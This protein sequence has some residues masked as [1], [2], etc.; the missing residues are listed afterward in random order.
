MSSS[1]TTYKL[2]RKNYFF[3]SFGFLLIISTV[4]ILLVEV[5]FK[6]ER[7]NYYSKYN[8]TQ[9]IVLSNYQNP[10]L[11]CQPRQCQ[12]CTRASLDTPS[13]T[14]LFLS[15]E[16]YGETMCCQNTEDC[17][18]CYDSNN[19]PYDCACSNRCI[20]E[21]D[22]PLCNNYCS[23]CFHPNFTVSY[24]VYQINEIIIKTIS[25][26]CSIDNIEC[27][28][29]FL[30]NRKQGMILNGYY[31][32]ENYYDIVIGN[33]KY[34]Y[35]NKIVIGIVICSILLFILFI[36]CAKELCIKYCFDEIHSNNSNNSNNSYKII[37]T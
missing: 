11:C 23:N 20:D 5:A 25:K 9:F 24:Y 35:I 1:T 14:N 29:N 3:V 6:N 19:N 4:I 22:R 37:K 18:T 36:C 2:F 17:V 28:Y 26:Q 21:N 34:S 10:Y 27:V 32:L 12:E 15:I 31:K 8:E 33:L 13:C 30:E 16:C 7:K